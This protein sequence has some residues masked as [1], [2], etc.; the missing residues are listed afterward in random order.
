M[1]MTDPNGAAA[2]GPMP[3]HGHFTDFLPDADRLALLDWAIA[4]H[5]TFKPAKIFYGEGGRERGVDLDV[6]TA[7]R[8]HGLGPFEQMM[9]D[10]LRERQPEILAAAGY[11]G[12][13]PSSIEFELNAYGEGAHFAPHIDIPLGEGRRTAGKNPGEDRVVSAVYYFYNEPKAF[14][15]GALRLFRFGADSDHPDD[16]NSIS[17]EPMQNSLLVFPA[18]GRHGVERVHSSSR[19]F[20][21]SRFALNCWFCRRLQS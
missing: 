20:G 3:P 5:A 17:F 11:A 18:W 15:G 2:L 9:T 13:Q 16:R 10:R 19:A 21:D 14:T 6:R 12:A 4:E 1:G 7:L 8:R